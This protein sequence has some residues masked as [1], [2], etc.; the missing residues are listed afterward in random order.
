M[1]FFL[2]WGVFSGLANFFIDQR[3]PNKLGRVIQGEIHLL[4]G[5]IVMEKFL[6]NSLYERDQ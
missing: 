5:Q 6:M 2:P 1:K 3:R 4:E